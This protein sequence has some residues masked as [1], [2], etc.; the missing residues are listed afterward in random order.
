MIGGPGQSHDTLIGQLLIDLGPNL[1][2]ASRLT[3][4]RRKF[5]AEYAENAE[6]KRLERRQRVP[7]PSH[8]DECPRFPCLHPE[9]LT[10][11]G[12]CELCGEFLFFELGLAGADEPPARS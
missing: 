6:Q 2:L 8:R 1:H 7:L 9:L 10:L 11:C 3:L 5:T 4:I 12:L